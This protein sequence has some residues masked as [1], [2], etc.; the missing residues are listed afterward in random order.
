MKESYQRGP[1]IH[2]NFFER[3][4][5][6]K[7]SCFDN[8]STLQWVK[9]NLTYPFC[10]TEPCHDVICFHIPERIRTIEILR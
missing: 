5:M 10:I 2:L 6:R 4:I 7:L 9:K 8:I 3:H 1:P